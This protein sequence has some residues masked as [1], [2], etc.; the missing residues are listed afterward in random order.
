MSGTYLE[1]IDPSRN[2]KRFYAV[3]VVPT[4]FG[5]WAM[6]REWGRIGQAGTIR[7]TWFESESEALSAGAMAASKKERRGYRAVG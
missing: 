5:Q 1:K 4:L 3:T 6:V 2:Q 7:Q